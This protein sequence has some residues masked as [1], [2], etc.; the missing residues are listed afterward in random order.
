MTRRPLPQRLRMGC[1][2]V[3]VAAA[4]ASLAGCSTASSQAVCVD[5]VSHTRVDDSRCNHASTS[6]V[7]WYLLRGQSAPGIGRRVT[8]G[9][10]VRPKGDVKLGG[11]S[12]SGGRVSPPKVSLFKS[13]GF[14]GSSGSRGFSGGRGGVK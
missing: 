14:K 6:F 13:G 10:N 9:S 7:W 8:A 11:V 12:R 5:H 2:V 1:A 3:A 4:A